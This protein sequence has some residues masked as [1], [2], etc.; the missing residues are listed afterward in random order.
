[1]SETRFAPSEPRYASFEEFWPFYVREHANPT[2]RLLHVVGTGIVLSFGLSA[3]MTGQLRFVVMMPLAGYG[4][5][6]LGHFVFQGNKPAT[7]KYPLWSLL[8]D[9]K[10]FGL[11]LAGTMHLEV[12][13]AVAMPTT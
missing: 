8:A 10:M 6:W 2:N 7:F 1:M 12:E 9:F 13:R 5:A 4:F 3:L 11:T